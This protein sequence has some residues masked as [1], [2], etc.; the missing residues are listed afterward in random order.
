MSNVIDFLER[1]GKD[2]DLRYAPHPELD[3]AMQEAQMS[4]EVRAALISGDQHSLEKLLG[5]SANV[6]CAIHV[7]LQEDEEGANE[8]E[9]VKAA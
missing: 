6:C 5:V 1:L 8:K 7:P 2:A 3:H 4:P 9:K